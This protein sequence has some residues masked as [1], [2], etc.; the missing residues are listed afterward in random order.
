MLRGGG[1]TLEVIV[2]LCA[3]WSVFHSA[4]SRAITFLLQGMNLHINTH[5][6]AHTNTYANVT[7]RTTSSPK[8]SGRE[9]NRLLL[10]ATVPR[11]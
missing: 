6:Q 9:T 1:N 8:E 7:I 5:S 11:T 10:S 3:L 4:R 2:V